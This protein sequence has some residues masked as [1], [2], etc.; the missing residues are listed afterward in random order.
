MPASKR[1]QQEA[2][3]WVVKC[4][5]GPLSPEERV[6]LDT[7]LEADPRHRGAYV[8]ADAARLNV[9]RVAALASGVTPQSTPRSRSYRI[10]M[11]ASFVLALV[12]V[13]LAWLGYENGDRYRSGVGELRKVALEDGSSMFLGTGSNAVVRFDEATRKI[14]LTDGEALFEV[15]KN[16][17]RPF[18]VRA[19]D[20][21][22]R[23]VGTVFSVQHNAT[24]VEVIVAEG[25][26]EIDRGDGAGVT[27]LVANQQAVVTQD[28]PVAVQLSSAD[29]TQRQLAWHTGRLEF[30][31]QTLSA[32]VAQINRYNRRQIVVADAR[33]AQHPVIGVFRSTDIEAFANIA[34]AA[35]GAE[36]IVEG[37][38]IRLEPRDAP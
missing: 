18:V 17:A 3:R 5:L 14:D 4:D 35:L 8:R 13:S 29:E 28:R 26:V 20:T 31:G 34:A 1:I 23:A 10:A 25:V 2:T 33:L 38:V 21:T 37:D 11:A 36:V 24:R 6:Q 27:R 7:W 9:E 19:G 30:D 32:A 12:L 22:V 15:A 16:P